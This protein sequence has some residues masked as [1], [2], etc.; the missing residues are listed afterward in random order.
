MTADRT[1]HQMK[2][3]TILPGVPDSASLKLLPIPTRQERSLL[4]RTEAIGICGTDRELIDGLY[5]AAPPGQR[6]LIIGHESLGTVIQADSDSRYT[7][8]DKV[9]GIV[10]R[11]DPEPCPACA[12]G[13]WDM[14]QNGRYTERGIFMRDGYCAEMFVL[15]EEYA[16]KVDSRLGI[17]GVLLEPMSIVAKGWEQIEYLGKRSRAWQPQRVL[18]TGAGPIGLLA[19]LLSRQRGLE[20]HLYDRIES[21]LKPKLAQDAGIHYHPGR[22]G[23]LADLQPDVIVECTGAPS[24]VLSAMRHNARNAVICLA[25]LSAAGRELPVD[26]AALNHS[27]VLQNDLVFGTVNANRHHYQLAAKALEC[28]DD[29]WLMRLISRRVPLDNWQD[30]LRRQPD[31]IKVVIDFESGTRDAH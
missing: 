16:I 6:H 11:P 22:L 19:A 25:G 10:R 28:A 12:L 9:V 13:E 15:E 17:A 26:L 14:C 21:G 29:A 31:D 4:I 27:M 23:T 8:G 3:L 20:T 2:A 7:P 18:V 24:V 1:A 30:A 5:G